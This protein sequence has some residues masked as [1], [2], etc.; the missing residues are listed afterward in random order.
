MNGSRIVRSLCRGVAAVLLSAVVSTIHAEALRARLFEPETSITKLT[1]AATLLKQAGFTVEPLTADSLAPGETDLIVFASFANYSPAYAG[2]IKQ[3]AAELRSFVEKG[4]VLLQLAQKEESQISLPFLPDEMR[5]S[6]GDACSAD[7]RVIARSHPLLHD[8]GDAA[9][10]V[11]L[12]SHLERAPGWHLFMEQR[13]GAVLLGAGGVD[14]PALIETPAGRGRFLLAS[15]FFDRLYADDGTRVAPPAYEAFAH[16]FM[17]NLA[18]Y[19]T[20]VKSG[21]APVVTPDPKPVPRPFVAGSWTLAVLPDTQYYSRSHP[22]VF[23]DQTKWIAAH[24]RD[25]NIKYVLHLGDITADNLEPQWKAARRAMSRLEGVVPYALVGG[26]HDYGPKGNSANRD[27]FLNEYFPVSKYEKWPTFGGTMEPGKIDNTY[28]LFEAGGKKWIVLALEWAPRDEVVAW[29]DKVLT[30]HP[31]RFG[32]LITHAYLSSDDTRYD[33]AKYGRKQPASPHYYELTHAPGTGNDG[34]ELWQKLVKRHPRMVMTIN[35]H[36]LED[37]VAR[38][39][40]TGDHGNVVHQTLVNYQRM[41]PL[42]G[43]GFLRLYEF[44]PDG[45]TIQVRSYSPVWDVYKTDM[46]NQFTLEVDL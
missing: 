4:G 6:R 39:S 32:I 18:E 37:G 28:H 7:L 44:L 14:D 2:F 34:E 19:V 27:S 13:G 1:G 5:A 15:L 41:R 8:L 11:S 33:W 12:P 20:A 30:T 25:R 10:R 38:L 35:G 26:N 45:K 17:R 42:N 22:E 40:S 46:Q 29:A 3:H 31:D 9:G 36:V 43:N 23:E 16:T 21:K 24:A